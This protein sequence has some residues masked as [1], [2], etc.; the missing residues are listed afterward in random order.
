[1]TFLLCETGLFWPLGLG[2]ERWKLI[3]RLEWKTTERDEGEQM[4][5]GN[6]EDESED[7]S[8]DRTLGE[9]GD[10][11]RSSEPDGPGEEETL[12]FLPKD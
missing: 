2:W 5:Q 12:A 4:Y 9:S 1:M 6:S 11:E 7:P 3:G 8:V 10:R